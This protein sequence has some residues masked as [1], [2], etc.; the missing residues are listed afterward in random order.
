MKERENIF[1]LADT[2]GENNVAITLQC[3]HNI[4]T[5]ESAKKTYD[6]ASCKPPS[7]FFFGGGRLEPSPKSIIGRN[8]KFCQAMH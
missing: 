2:G 1:Y 8:R 7:F 6:I 4:L 3:C 5:P